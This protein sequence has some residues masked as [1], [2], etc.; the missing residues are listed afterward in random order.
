MGDCVVTHDLE[1]DAM[2]RHPRS[3]TSFWKQ[4]VTALIAVAIYITLAFSAVQAW[5][6]LSE[7]ANAFDSNFSR[8]HTPVPDRT[9]HLQAPSAQE[10]ENAMVNG[11]SP[12]QG[13]LPRRHG[14]IACA[15]TASD[16]NAWNTM[17]P[18]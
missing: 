2:Q 11:A 13:F 17:L 8:A 10:H 15:A 6:F 7:E 1:G 16:C 4:D 14:T 12:D 5:S 3:S 9:V 18:K